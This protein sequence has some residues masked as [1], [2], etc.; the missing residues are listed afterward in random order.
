MEIWKKI[1]ELYSVSN[2]GRARNDKTGRLL[3]LRKTGYCDI[4]IRINGKR[5]KFYIHRLVA[6]AFIPNPNNYNIVNHK[7]ENPNNNHVDN[8]EWCTQSYNI[9]HGT[10]INRMMNSRTENCGKNAPRGV[11]VDDVFYRSLLLASKHMKCSHATIRYKLDEGKTEY[12][13]YK[14]RWAS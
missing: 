3:K 13:G 12:N 11:Y 5:K 6:E 10:S 8:L 2:Y 9:K 14:I 4:A 7:D 1:S